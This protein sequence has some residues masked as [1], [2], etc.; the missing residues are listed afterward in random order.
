MP[1]RSCW[2]EDR[3]FKSKSL[4][5]CIRSHIEEL[6][7]SFCYFTVRKYLPFTVLHLCC[8]VCIDIKSD[9]FCN[10]DCIGYL[11]KSLVAYSCCHEVFGNMSGRIGC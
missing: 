5:Y 8:S 7:D 1:V 3:I 11:Y 4:N 2:K 10:S 9:W 6:I